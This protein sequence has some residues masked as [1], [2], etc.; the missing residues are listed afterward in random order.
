MSRKNWVP[1]VS[2]IDLTVIIDG[3]LTEL[4]EYNFL[5]SFWKKFERLKKIFPMIGEVDILN[6]NQIDSW[7]KFTI[8]DYETREWKLLYGAK[9]VT[10]NYKVNRAL[11]A[12]D[13]LN[14]AITNFLEYF[15]PKFYSKKVLI[16]YHLQSYQD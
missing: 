11:L 10:S 8:R 13:S 3:S 7:T 2:D 16:L 4:Q 1:A 12:V 6:E 5:K 9:T 14:F 15:I